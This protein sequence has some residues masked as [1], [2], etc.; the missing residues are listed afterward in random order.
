MKKLYSL[1]ID[2]FK[3]L[4]ETVV[5]KEI[6]NDTC[7]AIIRTMLSESRPMTGDEILEKAVETGRWSTRQH[8]TKY[9]TTFAY[10]VKKL[11]IHAGMKCVGEIENEQRSVEN[12]LE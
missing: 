12:F 1:N 3:S 6:S 7:R 8:P 10:Y 11:K 9:H 4:N 5:H 2:T